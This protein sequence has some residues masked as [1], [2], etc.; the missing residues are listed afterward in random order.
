M[1][2]EIMI[3]HES[4]LESVITDIVT[5][6]VLFFCLYINYRYLGN[7]WAIKVLLIL[8]LFF[9]GYGHSDKNIYSGTREEAIKFLE[10]KK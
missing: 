8:L 2:K 7:D 3:I 1:D 9:F 4:V 5:F 10:N 6:S